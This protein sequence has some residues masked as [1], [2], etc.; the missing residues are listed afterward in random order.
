[1]L[2]PRT[3]CP[4]ISPALRELENIASLAPAYDLEAPDIAI[5]IGHLATRA[6][7]ETQA[8]SP[9]DPGAGD[10]DML[11]ALAAQGKPYRARPTD[12]AAWSGVGAAAITR[13]ADRLVE[14]CMVTRTYD[15]QDRRICWI[16][17]T[18]VGL[19]YLSKETSRVTS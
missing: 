9:A 3:S 13:R 14:R 15:D 8:K 6:K 1:M 12:L 10:V 18:R 16:T 17:L 19:R 7:T 5:S 2:P 11:V 4:E